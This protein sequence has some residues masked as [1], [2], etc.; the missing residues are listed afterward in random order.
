METGGQ[1]E[2]GPRRENLRWRVV[3]DCDDV[4][5]DGIGSFVGADVASSTTDNG[6]KDKAN[7]YDLC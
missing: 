2:L 3:E 1:F 7:G 4:G 6:K 5:G